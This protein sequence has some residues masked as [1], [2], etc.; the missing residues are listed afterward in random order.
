M[1][2]KQVIAAAAIALVG[3]AAFAQSEI[4]L[5]HFG[6]TQA[7]S[8]SRAEVRADVKRAQ[9]AGELTTPTEVQIAAIPGKASASSAANRAQVRAEVMQARST[10]ATPTE[11]TMFATTAAQ[12]ARSREDVRAEAR[13][14]V[15][16][17]A[18]KPH[19]STGY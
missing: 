8:V 10:L 6:A 13:Q 19:I 9:V 17:E 15:R 4:E 5:Q 12:P 2:T 11:V 14:F 18:A 7:P 16:S 1:N 3:S